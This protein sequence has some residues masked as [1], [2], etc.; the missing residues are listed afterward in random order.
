MKPPY[1]LFERFGV[2][3]EYAI[4]SRDDLR[5]LPICDRLLHAVC[6]AYESEVEM[7]SL[8]W[9]NELVLHVIEFKTNGPSPTLEGLDRQFQHDVQRVNAALEPL[10]ACLM[11]TAMHPWMNPDTETRLWP[12][13]YNAIYESFNRIFDCR[14]HGWANLQSTHLNLPFA[15]D[16]EFGRLH[17]AIRLILPILPALAASSPVVE[18][19]LPG[20]ADA[21]M[22]Y[23]CN[24]S[25]RIPSVAGKIIPEPVFTIADYHRRILEPMYGDI[26]PHDPEGILRHEWLNARGAIARFERHTIEIRV[27]DIQECPAADLAVLALIIAVLQALVR[28]EWASWAEQKSWQVEPLEEILMDTIRHGE[29]ARI[30]YSNYL[31]VFGCRLPVPCRAGDLWGHLQERALPAPWQEQFGYPLR[32]IREQGTLSRR[33]VRTLGAGHSHQDVAGVYHEL[34]HCLAEGRCFDGQAYPPAADL[35]A[36]RQSRAE[37]V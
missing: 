18:G 24:N 20:L 21:R 4:V 15:N 26:A 30:P 36:R 16:E 33:I 14:G 27:L 13:E 5:V 2:E 25:R 1:G 6:G 32:L 19:R 10:N 23:Y 37:A 28:E 34:C 22:E 9:S 8:S 11:P 7:G 35:R 31:Q 3:L 12:H 17:A 29:E